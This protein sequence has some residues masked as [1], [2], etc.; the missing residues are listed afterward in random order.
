MLGN[1]Y[2]LLGRKKKAVDIFTEILD[3]NLS[4]N[5]KIEDEKVKKYCILI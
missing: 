3:H 5:D 1:M 4:Y 2:T